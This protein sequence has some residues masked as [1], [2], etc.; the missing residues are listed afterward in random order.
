[1]CRQNE[2]KNGSSCRMLLHTC[3]FHSFSKCL[4]CVYS[5]SSLSVGNAWWL[6]QVVQIDAALNILSCAIVCLFIVP[7]D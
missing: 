5:F 1:M 6:M 7:S 2:R 4:I 3:T